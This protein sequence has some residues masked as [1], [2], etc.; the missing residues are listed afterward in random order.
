MNFTAYSIAFTAFLALYIEVHNGPKTL[1][2]FPY[3]PPLPKS[4]PLSFVFYIIV[5]I[6]FS[7]GSLVS[8]LL[9]N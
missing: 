6:Y 8:G 4:T 7:P 5:A 3:T 1:I 9:T 2:V